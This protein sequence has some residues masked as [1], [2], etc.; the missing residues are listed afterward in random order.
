MKLPCREILNYDQVFIDN[1]IYARAQL[2]GL[3]ALALNPVKKIHEIGN[4]LELPSCSKVV[5]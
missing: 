3:Y 4:F 2:T 1:I 5:L